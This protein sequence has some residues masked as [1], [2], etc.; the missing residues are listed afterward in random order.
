MLIEHDMLSVII[1]SSYRRAQLEHVV[2]LFQSISA[3]IERVHHTEQVKHLHVI[4][5]MSFFVL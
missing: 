2:S 5:H 3:A 4:T 1:D